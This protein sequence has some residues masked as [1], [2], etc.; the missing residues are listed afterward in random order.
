MRTNMADFK[1][2]I[3]VDVKDAPGKIAAAEKALHMIY[4]MCALGHQIDKEVVRVLSAEPIRSSE[5]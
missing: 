2:T 4:S 1:V 5:E 3:E